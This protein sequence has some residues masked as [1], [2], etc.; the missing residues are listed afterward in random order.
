[1]RLIWSLLCCMLLAACSTPRQ[2]AVPMSATVLSAKPAR[3]G[4]A[5]STMPKVDTYFP[6]ASCLLC[7][8]AASVAN[9]ALTAHVQTLPSDDLL[10]LKEEAAALLRKKGHEVV[11][12]AEAI[13]IDALPDRTDSLPNAARKDFSALG[14]QYKLDKLLVIQIARVGVN[15]TYNS[16][17][18]SGDPQG[19]VS[20]AGYLVNLDGQ[21]YDWY[22]TVRQL[23][24]ASGNWDEGPS[25]PGLSNAY[26]QAIEG[27]RDAFLKPLN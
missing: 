24:S 13:D 19:M 17:I 26:F 22:R 25:Y 4:V 2:A 16:Y 23:R 9:T 14:R 10:S 6:G 11:V 12:I 27:A 20:G 3:I 15:R 8:A 21:G 18:P 5:M 1:M 7:K